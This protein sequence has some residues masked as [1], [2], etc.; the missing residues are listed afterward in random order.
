MCLELLIRV[1][2][3]VQGHPPAM[4][5]VLLVFHTALG[6]R[7]ASALVWE[8]FLQYKRG[9]KTKKLTNKSKTNKPMFLQI[10]KLYSDR[11]NSR[12]Q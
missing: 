9:N 6:Q 3:M 2:G 4:L 12:N 10:F 7:L 5:Q 8:P 1:F 11:V